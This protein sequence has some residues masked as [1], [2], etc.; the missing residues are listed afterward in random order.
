LFEKHWKEFINSDDNLKY[1]IQVYTTYLST[2]P[3]FLTPKQLLSEILKSI[4]TN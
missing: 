4:V 3:T 2:F 1:G